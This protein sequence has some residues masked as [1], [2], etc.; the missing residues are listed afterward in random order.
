MWYV[1]QASPVSKAL[2]GPNLPREHD[3]FSR[4][5]QRGTAA[6]NNIKFL[7][8]NQAYLFLIL[9][10]LSRIGYLERDDFRPELHPNGI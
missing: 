10:G 2:Y 4:N 6:E 1:W 7:L 5:H 3:C 9:P 8:I